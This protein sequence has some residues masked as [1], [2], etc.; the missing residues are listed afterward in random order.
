MP[1]DSTNGIWVNSPLDNTGQMGGPGRPA[2]TPPGYNNPNFDMQR[3]AQLGSD[4]GGGF[5]PMPGANW[6]STF[7]SPMNSGNSTTMPVG[8]PDIYGG[9]GNLPNGGFSNFGQQQPNP[10]L[11][12]SPTNFNPVTPP[13]GSSGTYTPTTFGSITPYPLGAG[14]APQTNAA[15]NPD[16]AYPKFDPAYLSQV[17][18]AL[19]ASNGPY[20]GRQVGDYAPPGAADNVRNPQTQKDWTDRFY[21][22]AAHPDWLSNPSTPQA[23]AA[24]P[25]IPW[26]QFK[27]NVYADRNAQRSFSELSGVVDDKRLQDAQTLYGWQLGP[28]GL[29]SDDAARVQAN[30]MSDAH[31][32]FSYQVYQRPDNTWGIAAREL[33]QTAQQ[34]RGFYAPGQS[35]ADIASTARMTAAQTPRPVSS[36]YSGSRSSGG[37]STKSS[38]GG[39]GKTTPAATPQLTAAQIAQL[40]G[41]ATVDAINA[42]NAHYAASPQNKPVTPAEQQA[43][44]NWTR[45]HPYSGPY[46]PQNM[47]PAGTGL[48]ANNQP[49][50]Y[51]PVPTP[52]LSGMPVGTLSADGQYQWNGTGWTYIGSVG[53]GLGSKYSPV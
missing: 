8:N 24:G 34:G 4:Q 15:V 35:P 2:S 1:W 18:A 52:L 51:T 11:S 27:S 40:G 37:Y 46:S 45:S 41:Q 16:A 5:Q 13:G 21:A 26:Q 32:E 9:G 42:A 30:A 39:G 50:A 12:Y 31:P 44:S 3:Q 47:P 53:G 17:Q 43:I 36:T 49:P 33:D 7:G 19:E 20:A 6:Q 10:T 14:A 22:F 28:N 23:A 25:T 48:P 29:P 38:G